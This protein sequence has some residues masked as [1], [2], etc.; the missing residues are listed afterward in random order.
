MS[1]IVTIE[2]FIFEHQPDYARGE[3][4]NLLYDIALSAKIIAQ[5]TNRAGLTDILGQAGST[6][7]QGEDQQKL[8]VYADDI[9]FRLN[10][11]T[12]RICVMASEEREEIISIPEPYKKGS[13][14]LV[15]DP[16]D[17]SSNIDVN[18]S[19][20]TVFG[21]YR[22]R[23]YDK[24]GRIEDVL[25]PA[26]RLVG[27]GYVLY[28]SSTM[29]VYT[30]GQGVHGF[31]LNPDLGE[32]LL[33]HENMVLPDPPAYYSVN[34]AYYSRWEKSVQAFTDWLQGADSPQMSSRYIGSL[35]ADFH[36][37]L[38]KGG[39]FYYP[40]E[41]EKPEGKIRLL[42]EAGPL[43]MLIDQAG[44]YA[45]NGC[46]PILDVEIDSLH[47]RTPFYIGNRSLVHRAEMFIQQLEKSST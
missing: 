6:N 40:G 42:Y 29:L 27:A 31:T 20:G 45:S 16:L 23:E 7:I 21:I 46:K 17:G 15:Y 39:I 2:R 11:H 26:R 28:G 14:V 5:K 38:L 8:D 13:Y 36:R 30:T 4:T 25:Q 9:I 44:G 37:N 32:F 22:C 47:Q 24:R 12:G 3:F 18:V 19:I 10:D 43:A 34:H 35:V 33:S 41:I 1:K